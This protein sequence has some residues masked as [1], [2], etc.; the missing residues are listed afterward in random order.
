MKAKPA[1]GMSIVTVAAAGAL[2]AYFMD[3]KQGTQRRAV[4]RDKVSSRIGR[5]DEAGRV[6][7]TDLSN[8]IQGTFSTLRRRM[9]T[10]EVPDD[11]LIERVRS[12]LGRVATH[13]GSIDV[14]ATK[15][16]VT[17]QG[18]V[19]KQ[20]LKRILSAVSAI[21]GVHGVIDRLEVHDQPSDIP[22]L[23]GGHPRW[24]RLDIRQEQWAPATRLLV[25]SAGMALG[26]YG[27]T[28]RSWVTP[29]LTATG[30]AL[31]LRAGTN[32]DARRLVGLRD[33]RGIHFTK[34]MFIAAPVDRVFTFWSD[35]D[36]FPKFM[37]NVRAVSR[38][39]EDSWHWE[40]AGPVGS[41][42]AWDAVVTQYIPNEVIAWATVPGTV[43][44]H[45]GTVRFQPEGSGTRVQIQMSY[46][47]PAGV[48]GH[49]VASLFGADPQTEMGE[50]IAR[51]K[52]Y[53]ETGKPARDAVSAS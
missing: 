30:I 22:G 17:L 48:L 15:G 52:S 20:D 10:K 3:A 26:L 5:L 24:Q 25:G 13:P 14:Q 36:N 9:S 46:S 11:V 12:K 23:Q 51:L 16:T 8:R 31:L 39:R 33:R 42:I 38:N 45:A 27:L 53:F 2:A 44:E 41:K 6:I 35:F 28:R 34:T 18:P 7:G 37:R 50:D 47:P 4:V 40:V 43:V 32:I 1:S 49:A 21:P 19:L 29:L